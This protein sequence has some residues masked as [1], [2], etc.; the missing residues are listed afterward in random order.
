MPEIKKDEIREERIDMEIIVD[1]YGTEEQAMGWYYYLEDKIQFPF[2]ARCIKNVGKSPLRKGE[3][4]IVIKMADEEECSHGMFVEI[5]WNNR[6][7]YIPLE[8]LQ[9]INTD[10]ETMEAV[11]DWH[12]WI[13]RGYEL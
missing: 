4:V 9:P 10:D 3:E 1:A 2:T 13:A 5:N 8:Q 11:E 6:S 7:F 12:Y